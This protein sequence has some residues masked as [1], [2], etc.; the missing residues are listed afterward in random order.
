MDKWNMH[1]NK[2]CRA[3]A[4]LFLRQLCFHAP[5]SDL[6]LIGGERRAYSRPHTAGHIDR[7]HV[8]ELLTAGGGVV[9]S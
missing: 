6:E 1:V 2:R 5:S 7:L 4:S 9:R 8:S 3:A